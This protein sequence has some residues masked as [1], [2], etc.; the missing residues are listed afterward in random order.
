M[1]ANQ[2]NSYF[3]ALLG[4]CGIVALP[5]YAID[6]APH[7]VTYQLTLADAAPKAGIEGISGKTV[8]RLA[9]EC[10]GWKSG[11]DYAMTIAF[12]DGNN[13]IMASLFESFEDEAG[14][15]FSFEIDERSNY[16]APLSFDGFAQQ[17]NAA[18]RAGEAYFSIEPD[19]PMSLPDDTYFPIAQ[20]AEI[21]R[22]ARAGETFFTSHIFFGAKPDNALK[23][24]SV[25]IGRAQ[26][27][28]AQNI[29]SELLQ[30]E[31]YP[32]QVAYF[33][34]LSTTGIPSYE[35][36][37]HMQDNGVVPFYLI[38]YGDF[39]LQAQMSQIVKEPSPT[40]G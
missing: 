27:S 20:T 36:S 8:F 4:V 40:C 23:K 24:T 39:K 19:S 14:T 5:A 7:Q 30:D 18:S 32:V 10:E 38:D 2:Y 1:K 37:F 35:I 25:V 29:T 15:L 33:D 6:L 31:F 17:L 3:L 13:V 11:E 12:E 34:P 16:E 22:R 21:L 26:Q 9:K 28:T